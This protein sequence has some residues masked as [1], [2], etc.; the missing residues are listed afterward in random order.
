M[1]KGPTKREEAQR[2]PR[3]VQGKLSSRGPF[4]SNLQI[5]KLARIVRGGNGVT[6]RVLPIHYTRWQRDEAGDEQIGEGAV[7]N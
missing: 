2:F 3:P 4:Q 6:Y 5:A 1:P 7:L